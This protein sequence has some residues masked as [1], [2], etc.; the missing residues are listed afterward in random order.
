M[1]RT[2][3]PPKRSHL[4]LSFFLLILIAYWDY[5]T[6]HEIDMSVFY[7]LPVALTAWYNGRTYG[8][9]AAAFA[10]SLWALA[11][12]LEDYTYILPWGIYWAS[13]THGLFFTMTA[14]I[15]FRLQQAH[16]ALDQSANF[17][18]L[19]GLLNRRAFLYLAEKECL[20][21][22]RYGQAL[23]LCY[24]DLDHF[25]Q[26][27]DT[28]GH[29]AGDQLLQDVSQAM[30]SQVRTT[31]LVG[32]LGGDEFALLLTE[33]TD[34]TPA[35]IDRIHKGLQRSMDQANWPV[36][37]SIGAVS[38]KRAPE[39]I[40]EYIRQA[41]QLMYQVKKNGKNHFQHTVLK[42]SPPE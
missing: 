31:D 39:T 17:D 7:L 2:V 24:I 9:I 25:K 41:D 30:L 5:L 28:M 36:T 15:T 3:L 18:F 38:C 37:F 34:C 23:T 12:W 8:W 11:D 4:I 19:T 40:D 29:E 22:K 6:I 42:I 13:A 21:S 16:L 27:N 10:V 20:R 32:R 1:Q 35:L 26:V 14:E 33:T